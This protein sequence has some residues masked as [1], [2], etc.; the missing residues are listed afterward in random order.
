MCGVAG[1]F[2]KVNFV[3]KKKNFDKIIKIMRFRGPDGTGSFEKKI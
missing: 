3:N 2:G 1:Y